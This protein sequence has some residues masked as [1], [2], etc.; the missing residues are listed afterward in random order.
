MRILLAGKERKLIG[1]KGEGDNQDGGWTTEE[2]ANKGKVRGIWI[3]Y[4]PLR[5]ARNMGPSITW[6][7]FRQAVKL[8]KPFEETDTE[9]LRPSRTMSLRRCDSE[10]RTSHLC[11]GAVGC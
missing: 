6:E 8:D 3:R 10:E 5:S 4:N 9:S 1:K 7:G 2:E 11:P